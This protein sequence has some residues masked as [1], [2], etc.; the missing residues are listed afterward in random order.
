MTNSVGFSG[1]EGSWANDLWF[2][3]LN[4]VPSFATSAVK[5]NPMF[6]SP[7]SDYHLAT[8]SPAIGTGGTTASTL[9]KDDLYG[10]ARASTL[11][12]GTIAH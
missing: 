6:V 2:N 5:A 1:A 4:G 11:D 12:I 3:A 9:I 7:G 10:K 8:G